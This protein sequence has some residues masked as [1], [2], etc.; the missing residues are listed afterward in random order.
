MEEDYSKLEGKI[1]TLNVGRG[2]VLK[3]VR[4]VGCDPDI[5]ISLMN[6]D[7]GEYVLCSHGPMSP[8]LKPDVKN[9][10]LVSHRQ[11]LFKGIVAMIKTG[12]VCANTVVNINSGCRA[13]GKPTAKDCA[14]TQ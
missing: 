12:T 7:T 9:T 2:V 5:G 6:A 1:I 4:V 3:N 14:F 11:K 13:D 10:R 8:L